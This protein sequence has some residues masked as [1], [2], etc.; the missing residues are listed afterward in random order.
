MMENPNYIQLRAWAESHLKVN[1]MQARWVIEA[2]REIETLQRVVDGLRKDPI[3]WADEATPFTG[4]EVLVLLH[5]NESLR[6]LNVELTE[7]VA[8]QSELLSKRAERVA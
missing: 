1:L 7:R 5:E 4:P 6:A 3:V 2:L 8:A